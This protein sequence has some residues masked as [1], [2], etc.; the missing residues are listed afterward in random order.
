MAEKCYQMFLSGISTEKTRE[1]YEYYLQRFL[2]E[3][4]LKNFTALIELDDETR[5]DIVEKYILMLKS[6]DLILNSSHI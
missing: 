4:K 1:K 2:K 3:T 6:R 5:Q